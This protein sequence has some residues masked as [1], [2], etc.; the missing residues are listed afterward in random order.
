MGFCIW[1]L[2]G[3]GYVSGY[4]LDYAL[5]RLLERGED[6]D[7]LADVHLYVLGRGPVVLVL[8]DVKCHLG[9]ARQRGVHHHLG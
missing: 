6:A 1:D 5:F 8:E 3:L 4:A 2:L 9:V 7:L